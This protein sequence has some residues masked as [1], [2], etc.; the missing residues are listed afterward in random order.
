MWEGSLFGAVAKGFHKIRPCSKRA[1][2]L[3]VRGKQR[4]II[5]VLILL[6]FGRKKSK[7]AKLCYCYKLQDDGLSLL[8]DTNLRRKT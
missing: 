1:L 8:Q 6:G 5:V 3:V 4:Q 2:A 7:I